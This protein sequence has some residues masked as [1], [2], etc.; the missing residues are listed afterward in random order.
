MKSLRNTEGRTRKGIGWEGSTGASKDQGTGDY[1]PQAECKA[2]ADTRNTR[3]NIYIYDG[4]YLVFPDFFSP[5]IL[6]PLA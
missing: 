5:T 1:N 3:I 4:G 2:P 6:P